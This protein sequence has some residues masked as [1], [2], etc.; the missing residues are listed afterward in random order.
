MPA[1]ESKAFVNVEDVVPIIKKRNW[2]RK[3]CHWMFLGVIDDCSMDPCFG[4][5]WLLKIVPILIVFNLRIRILKYTITGLPWEMNTVTCYNLSA[6]EFLMNNDLN[7]TA[8]CF[9]VDYENPKLKTVAFMHCLAFGN[10]PSIK[11]QIEST[12]FWT[13]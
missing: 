5:G 7:I 2:I 3:F 13:L 12:K 10:L 11:L 8:T 6:D 4:L 1:I 9:W